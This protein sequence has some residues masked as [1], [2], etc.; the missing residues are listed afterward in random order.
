MLDF[1]DNMGVVTASRNVPRE[2]E[3]SELGSFSD[4]RQTPMRERRH[5]ELGSFSDGRQTPMRERRHS[6]PRITGDATLWVDKARDLLRSPR[7]P[8]PPRR[9]TTRLA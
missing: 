2:S 7:P 9:A 8:P 1:V 6:V 4:G 5:S 3:R